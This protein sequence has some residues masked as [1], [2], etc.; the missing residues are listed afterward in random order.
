[1]DKIILTPAEIDGK[2]T[3]LVD[4]QGALAGILSLASN[5]EKPLQ[6]SDFSIE[7]I[8]LIARARRSP[9]SIHK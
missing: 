7:S 9:K 4:L 2:N 3:A 8:K 1:M 6:E 5:A